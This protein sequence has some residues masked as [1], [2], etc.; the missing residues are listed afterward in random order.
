MLAPMTE[1]QFR[2]IVREELARALGTPPPQAPSDASRE[3]VRA[4]ADT[5]APGQYRAADL[6]G[7]FMA[8]GPGA[9]TFLTATA[10]GRRMKKCPRVTPCRRS[11]ARVYLV[12]PDGGPPMRERV[13]GPTEAAPGLAAGAV[14]AGL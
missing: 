14:V 8:S 5:L 6:L 9:G 13:M 10:F 3:Q 12:A 11:G 2:L 7:R 1:K 4:F